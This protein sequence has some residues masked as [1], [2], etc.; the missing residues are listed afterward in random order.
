MRKFR[1][2]IADDQKRARDSLKALI[3]TWERAGELKEAVNG[4]EA[5]GQSQIFDPDIILMDARMFKLDGIQA[6]HIIKQTKPNVKIII[7]S[8]FPD[9]D[10]QASQISVDAFVSKGESPE[11]LLAVIQLISAGI[12]VE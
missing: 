9:Y 3:S 6:A 8:M 1:I 2:L 11:R 4:L 7:V 10:L 5:I 12:E